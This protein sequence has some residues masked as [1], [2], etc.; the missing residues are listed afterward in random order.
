VDFRLMGMT[1]LIIAYTEYALQQLRVTEVIH[2]ILNIEHGG[3]SKLRQRNVVPWIPPPSLGSCEAFHC[4][5]TLLTKL[6]V[7][8]I[9]YG[10]DG[11]VIIS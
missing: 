3:I 7:Y 1:L 10:N 2:A 11:D 9:R 8:S 6:L 4:L 5:A